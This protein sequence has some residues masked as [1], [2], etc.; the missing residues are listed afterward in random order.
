MNDDNTNDQ[1]AAAPKQP[2][3]AHQ[4][5][6]KGLI[7]WEDPSVPIGNAPPLPRWPVAV[8]ALVWAGWI[9]LLVAMVLSPHS[10]HFH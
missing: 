1:A 7:D 5:P 3:G 8:S 2:D 6:E 9:A 4:D 10:T